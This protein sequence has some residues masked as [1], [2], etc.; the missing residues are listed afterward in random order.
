MSEIG[1]P[2]RRL[3]T[4][5]GTDDGSYS[6]QLVG[7]PTN[8]EVLVYDSATG[9]WKPQPPASPS[10]TVSVELALVAASLEDQNPPGLGVAQ[11]ITLGDAQTGDYFSV[12]ASG[13]VTC[14]QGDEYTFRMRFGVGREGGQG[15]AQIYIRALL[16]GVPTDFTA[17]AIVD[18]ARI[19]MPLT[20]EGVVALNTNDVVTFE[21]IRDTDG[22]DSGGL[23]AGIPDVS[24]NPSPSVLLTITRFVASS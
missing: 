6:P 5:I 24:W 22:N 12:D 19:E 16:N 1:E 11:Q 15:E 23:R 3:F 21:M 13:A 14:L 7:E 9:R 17:V 10:F 20:F 18:N 2:Q 8:G 4:A